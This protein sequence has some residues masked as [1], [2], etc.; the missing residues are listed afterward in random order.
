ME[1][2]VVGVEWPSSI[3]AGERIVLPAKVGRYRDIAI[4]VTVLVIWVTLIAAVLAVE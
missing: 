3:F 1:L 2:G 4:L